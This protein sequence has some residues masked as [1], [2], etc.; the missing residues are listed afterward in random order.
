M[1]K[2]Y[3]LYDC[4]SA[5]HLKTEMSYRLEILHTTQQKV[6]WCSLPC[7]CRKGCCIKPKLSWKTKHRSSRDHFWLV[8]TYQLN[9]PLGTAKTDVPLQSGQPYGCPVAAHH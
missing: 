3:F 4:L 1:Q 2:F 7:Y 9:P 5:G 6:M 8:Y